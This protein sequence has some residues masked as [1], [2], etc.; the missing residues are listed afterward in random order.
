MS[1]PIV[2]QPIANQSSDSQV[3]SNPSKRHPVFAI[4]LVSFLALLINC[5][6]VI[7]CGRSFAGTTGVPMLYDW[8]PPLPGME[9]V[10]QTTNHGSDTP[11][12]LIGE[13]PMGFIESRSIWEHG[14]LPLW[15]RYGH[16]G[17]TLI[18]QAISMIGDPL[19]AIVILGHGSAV[20]WDIK[21][22]FAKLLFCV[23]SGL[24]ILRLTGNRL[25][26]VIY[27]ALAAYCGAF[28]YINNHPAFF[29]FS[30]APWILLSALAFLDLSSGKFVRWGLVWLLVNFGCFNAG[31]VEPAVVLIGGLNLAA[32]L[33][34][35][36]GH[37][38]PA[39]ALRI[40]GR[41]GIGT[42]LFLGLT[43]PIWMSFLSILGESYSSHTEIEVYQLPFQSV[44]GAF[45]DM[46]YQLLRT[47]INYTAPAPGCSL[48][49]LVGCI[50]SVL[51]WRRMKG[52]IF[53]W[54]NCA[55]IV[56]VGGCIFALVPEPVLAAIPFINRVG[57]LD[58]ELS[59]LLIIQLTI[60]SAY[61]F[62]CLIET[63]DFRRAAIDLFF[64]TVVLAGMVWL[65][66]FVR[67]DHLPV[68]W[69]YVVCTATGAIGAPL[70]YAFMATRH[71][72]IPIIGWV[73]I[74]LLAFIPHFRFGFYNMGRDTWLMIPGVRAVLD[75]PSPAIEEIKAASPEPFRVAGMG[76]NLNGDYAAVYGLEDIRSCAPLSNRDLIELFQ[77]FPGIQFSGTWIVWISSV[78]KA[79]PLLN[80]LNVK[81][82]LGPPQ[83]ALPPGVDYRLQAQSDFGVVENPEVW[84]RAFFSG[85]IASISSN[86]MFIKK[87]LQCATNPFIALTPEEIEKQP[88]LKTL[89]SAQPSSIT[90]ATD[91]QL[92]PNSTAFDIHAASAGVVC[93]TEGQSKD[94]FATANGEAKEVLTVNRA[95]KGIYLDQ[96]GDFHIEFVYRPHH[97]RLA[98]GIFW[99]A[100]AAAVLLA[101]LRTRTVKT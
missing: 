87:L 50:L 9:D 42:L 12:L 91:Y 15:N 53:F 43:A 84:P 26:S 62:K 57:H 61:G 11:A 6:P 81:Y 1:Q 75:A 5:Y 31:H 60:Q 67:L 21:F 20:A 82:L 65:F 14:E 24:L 35:L 77:N 74:I 32:L 97:W 13:I 45:D 83:V 54:I 44:I 101:A 59:Y 85:Q 95:F 99:G 89:V 40:L 63:F 96:P 25:L 52:D 92:L 64:A 58:T 66:S 71:P 39:D 88:G 94:F 80:M 3:P 49:I 76:I 17:Y 78:S 47:N 7:F 22:L 93:L 98:C 68:P 8:W 23:G 19:Q 55:G 18:G 30:Y 4:L 70:L 29:V 34:S 27:A 41:I 16:A 72:R 51:R 48:L 86:E 69:G 100:L 79:Q 2:N 73:G 28:F 36:L 37:R 33:Y 10:P 90:P 56:L 46:F 38:N